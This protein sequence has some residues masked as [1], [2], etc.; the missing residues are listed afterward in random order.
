MA[1]LEGQRGPVLVEPM[2]HVSNDER[3]AVVVARLFQEI[4]EGEGVGPAGYGHERAARLEPES[5]QG[6]LELLDQCHVES[7]G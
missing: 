7:D 5:R 1:Y 2:V 4:E 6:G 3:Q